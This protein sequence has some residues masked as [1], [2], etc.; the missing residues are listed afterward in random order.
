MERVS[1]DEKAVLRRDM[2]AIRRVITANVDERAHRSATLWANVLKALGSRDMQGELEVMMFDSLP[3]E[4]DT[5]GWKYDASARGWRVYAPEVDGDALR[6]MPGDV[7]PG[8]LDVVLV[9]GLAFTP[10]GHRLGQGGGHYD[11]FLARLRGECVTVGVCFHEQVVTEL[12][13]E[14]HDILVDVVVTDHPR[15]A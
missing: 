6:V 11:R 9:P 10:D 14:E 3:T 5:A 12:P 8:L 4:P 13:V 15:M 7:D 2:R 1:N